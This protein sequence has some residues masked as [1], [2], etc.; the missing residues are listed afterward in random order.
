M[1]AIVKT[2]SNIYNENGKE[3]EVVELLGSIIACKVKN[4]LGQMVTA[5]F[6]VE[7]ELISLR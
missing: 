2:K 4:G 6:N 1:K 5:D 7:T 3:L